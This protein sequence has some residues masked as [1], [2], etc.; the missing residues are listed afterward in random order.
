MELNFVGRD[1]IS[2]INEAVRESVL[3]LRA[4]DKIEIL[5]GG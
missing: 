3:R 2:E 1:C 4:W 5:G